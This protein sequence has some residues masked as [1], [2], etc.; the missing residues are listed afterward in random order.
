MTLRGVIEAAPG[1]RKTLTLISR[2][3]VLKILYRF[4]SRIFSTQLGGTARVAARFSFA[5]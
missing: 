5:K 1:R 2:S 3:G 4:S